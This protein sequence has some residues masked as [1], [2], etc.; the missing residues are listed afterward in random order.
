[1]AMSG[2]Q[3]FG[4]PP[5]TR[6]QISVRAFLDLD[7]GACNFVV[8]RYPPFGDF[9]DQYFGSSMSPK[10]T[11]YLRLFESEMDTIPM[12]CHDGTCASVN[13]VAFLSAHSPAN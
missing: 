4:T 6:T 7:S 8:G 2:H 13:L 9:I 12:V 10:W 5:H 11:P 3:C 1:M